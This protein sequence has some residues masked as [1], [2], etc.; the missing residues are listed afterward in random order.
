MKNR[1]TPLWFL[2]I[3]VLF[4]PSKEV[5]AANND[6]EKAIA[7]VVQVMKSV[8]QEQYDVLAFEEFEKGRV[9]LADARLG[10][11]E[12]YMAETILE[13][14][15]MAKAAFLDA[16][17]KAK[18]RKSKA[19]RILKD[20]K[21]ALLAGVRKSNALVKQMMEIDEELISETD[22]FSESLDPDDFS[23]IQKKYY[24]LE[25]RA[26][27]FSALNNA[28]QAIDQATEDD[29]DD[30]APK[31]LRTALLDYKTAMNKIDLSPRNPNVYKKS[32]DD[33][34]VSAAHL[35]DVMNVIKGAEGT[36]EQIAVQ[37]VKQKRALG[38]LS[39]SVGKLQANLKSTK[40]TLQEKEGALEQVDT[41]LKQ[42]DTALKQT[43]TALKQKDSELKQ[44]EGVLKTQEEQLA[45]ASTQ[46][47]FQKAMDEARQMIPETDALVYQQGNKLVFRLKRVNFRS[48]TAVIPEFSK[49]LIS[50]VDS[51]IKKL[52]ANK[53]IVQ[54]HTDSVG[55]AAVNKKL[56]T[57]RATAVAKYLYYLRGGYKITYAG[58]G[59]SH[60]IAPNE[61]VAGRATNRRV[62]L[63][64]TVKQ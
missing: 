9:F 41:V 8:Q 14:A 24:R 50:K 49:S 44:K 17:E 63:V 36:P 39:S 22:E 59:E 19:G 31:S 23:E 54:G 43:E 12:E 47:R 18:T 56:S 16:V 25:T 6:P 53:V 61:T 60:P 38:E 32:V 37:I 15:A 13:N 64:V 57:A 4:G 11:K 45:R 46:V 35:N 27:Q 30:V 51:I 21:A 42:K 1:I 3:A 55:S 33:A 5:L 20:R 10:I 58:Y 40:Q 28:K 48:G 29:A 34:L 62:D 26:I 7:E 52:D 2:M